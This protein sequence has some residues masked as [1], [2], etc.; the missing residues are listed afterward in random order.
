ML[1]L[2]VA[3]MILPLAG[4]VTAKAQAGS[5]EQQLIERY[6]PIV[7]LKVQDGACDDDGEPFLPA[8][9]DV[10]LN[11]PTVLLKQGEDGGSSA[12]D[13][14][15]A[16]GPSAQ[17]L[18][19]V[20]EDHYLDLP[21]KP[22]SPGCDYETWF[23]ERTDGFAPTTYAR[24]KSNGLDQLAVQSWFFY[25]YNN[26]NNKHESDWEMMQLVW[27]VPTVEEALQTEPASLV[28]A[29]H[30]GGE[31]A[32]WT[33]DKVQRDGNHPIVYPAAGSHSTQYGNAVY[34]G[35]GENGTGF[36]CDTTTAPSTLVRLEPVLM[37][38]TLPDASSEFAWL[39]FE[40][41]WGERQK[42]E[43]NGPTGPRTKTV[44][45]SPFRWQ[46]D[47]RDSS[48]E[49]PT[50]DTFGP[51]PTQVFCTLSTFGSTLFT[52][53]GTN[54]AGVIAFVVALFAGIAVLVRMAR[55]TIG[56]SLAFYRQYWRTFAVV[57]LVLIPIGLL[58]N[59]FQYLVTNYP[60]GETFF[61]LLDESGSVGQLVAAILAGVV[62][63][64]VGLAIVGPAI[65]AAYREAERGERVGV[66]EAYREAIRQFPESARAV[67]LAAVVIVPLS[68]TVI[69]IPFAL[70]LLVRWFFVSQAVMLD[71]E[72]GRGALS[73]SGNVVGSGWNWLRTAGIGLLL[74][75]I[76]AAPGPLI[77][78]F[79]LIFRSSSVQIANSVSSLVYAAFLP[80]SILGFT[81]LYRELQNRTTATSPV[82]VPAAPGPESAPAPAG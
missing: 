68:L 47:Q 78:L 18:H 32:A 27:D 70:W 29:Q 81:I 51:G 24:V 63:H 12:T 48:M 57:G 39:T 20:D 52:D 34:L 44:W 21:G 35:W 73:R 7:A 11:D 38:E 17:D 26:F 64:L 3:V 6:A 45:H 54:P 42:G 74:F 56:E 46:E 28:L 4:P 62:Q 13:P 15:M 53:L 66:I 10:V 5:A 30:G 67:L 50:S 25:V 76:G 36:G 1:V 14:V 43:Y 58:F 16:D 33:D 75:T 22:R 61:A 9:V 49:V 59:G 55:V 71:D 19:N 69:G 60:P 72:R 41:R 82:P 2:V 40:G 77:G 23:K 65:I 8:P 31:T 79:L 37:P 80:F